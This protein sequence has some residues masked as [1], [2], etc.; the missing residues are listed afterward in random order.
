MP[1]LRASTIHFVSPIE[2][3]GPGSNTYSA[4]TRPASTASRSALKFGC[5]T[6][7]PTFP[8]VSPN[9]RAPFTFGAST[10]DTLNFVPSG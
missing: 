6:S 3:S 8:A 5:N 9:I 1:D 4:D 7:S 2:P 10:G